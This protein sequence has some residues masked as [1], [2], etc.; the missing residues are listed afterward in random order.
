MPHFTIAIIGAGFSGTLLALHLMQRCPPCTRV[1]LIER[2][3]QFGRGQ[4]YATSNPSHLLNVPAGRMS[5]YQNK[6]DDFIDWLHRLPLEDHL[7]LVPNPSTFVP[8]QVFGRYIR[9]LLNQEMKLDRGNEL[10]L[11]R[12]SAI[13][14]ETSARGL[15][16]ALDRDR[17]IEADIAVL[18][19]GNFPPE[20]PQV[21]DPAFYDGPLYHADPW[22]PE[23]LADLDPQASVL[24]I[25]TG[26]TMADTVISLL[27][28]G[29]EGP[30]TALSRRGLL[31]QRHR[32]DPAG[33]PA[34]MPPFPAS[35][36]ALARQLRQV[37][38]RSLAAGGS[39]QAIIDQLRPFTADV[40][41][42]MSLKDRQRFLRHLRPW[43]DT[44]RHRLSAAVADRIEAARQVGRLAVKAGRIRAYHG[45]E[46]GTVEVEFR[47]RFGG[48]MERVEA[49][50][51]INCAGPSAD[52]ARIGDAFVRSL[53][54]RGLVRPDPLRLGL[55]VT[56]GCAL[57][58]RDGAISRRLFAIGPV[59]RGTF[60]EMTAVPDIRQQC[61][62][63]AGNI[64]TQVRPRSTLRRTPKSERA[65]A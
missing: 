32:A 16:I 50:R 28:Q 35:L 10:E 30:I 41:Q 31:P 27:D 15:T 47:Q 34:D 17:Q 65:E 48:A 57:R 22:A 36:N 60:W 11:L 23:T 8:R 55:D 38:A 18:A 33:D 52:Y 64:A 1:V 5:A 56:A 54:E 9:H 4:A 39:W 7:G 21:D 2:N 20:A 14:M 58:D 6:P 3:S 29:H 43:W 61:E 53:L 13:G 46:R 19:V 59:T 25:G 51:V 44:H 63:L 24:V 42:T 62:F 49:A 26:L 40:W 45:T 12:A 37:S